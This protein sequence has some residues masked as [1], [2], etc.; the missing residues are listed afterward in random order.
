MN[1]GDVVTKRPAGM[2]GGWAYK[3]YRINEK[4]I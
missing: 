2:K 3:R 1:K 4:D